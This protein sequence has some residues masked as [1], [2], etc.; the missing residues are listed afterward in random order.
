MTRAILLALACVVGLGSGACRQNDTT[1]RAV[2]TMVSKDEPPTSLKGARWKLVRQ[3]YAERDYR[4][5]WF[6]GDKLRRDARDLIET[7]C[8]AEREG[9]R[10]SDYD[11]AGLRTELRKL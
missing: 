9:L 3:V 1:T 5:L 7:L 10:A 6:E 8:H 11:L 4:P 2:R